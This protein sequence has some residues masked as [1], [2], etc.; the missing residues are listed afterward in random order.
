MLNRIVESGI[1]EVREFDELYRQLPEPKREQIDRRDGRALVV[2]EH[3][4]A[5]RQVVE[6]QSERQPRRHGVHEH[7]PP[8]AGVAPTCA[9]WAIGRPMHVDTA[10]TRMPGPC[11]RSCALS[12]LVVVTELR[13]AAGMVTELRVGDAIIAEDL[14]RA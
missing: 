9:R 10:P 11:A 8:A 4:E 14:R 6:A 13:P 7:H 1:T 2:A 3:V 12:G 5:R